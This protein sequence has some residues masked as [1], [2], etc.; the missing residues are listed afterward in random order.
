MA[1][2]AAATVAG[3]TLPLAKIG[4]GGCLDRRV[5][6]RMRM[7]EVE[8]ALVRYHAYSFDDCPPSLGVLVDERILLRP[9][10][11]AW[12]QPLIFICPGVHAADGDLISAGPDHVF[13]TGDDLHSWD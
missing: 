8:A 9:P 7:K 12:R 4:S 1:L 11:D 3:V 2:L 6:T 5:D 10:V 13:G